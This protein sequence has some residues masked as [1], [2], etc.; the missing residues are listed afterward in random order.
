[1]P[2]EVLCQFLNQSVFFAIELYEF[3]KNIFQILTPFQM[4]CR[5][6]F[7][8]HRLFFLLMVSFSMQRFLSLRYSHLLILLSLPVRLV[9]KK[10]IIG[11][12]NQWQGAYFLCFL[13]G[14]LRLQDLDSS[15]VSNFYIWLSNFSSA[16]Y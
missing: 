5:Y 3:F 10:K 13:L 4:T 14:V 15:P 9:S 12:Q 16:I 8:F 2:V 7:S 1:M 6:A 11:C